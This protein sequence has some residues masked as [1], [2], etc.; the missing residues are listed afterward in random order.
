MNVED[1]SV[2][3]GKVVYDIQFSTQKPDTKEPIRLR[4]S[5]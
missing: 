3:E 1:N 2:R 5:I 4:A